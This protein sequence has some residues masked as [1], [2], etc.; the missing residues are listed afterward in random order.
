MTG[1]CIGLALDRAGSVVFSLLLVQ[2]IDA[3]TMGFRL[4]VVG[5]AH[6]HDR[7]VK[8]SKRVGVVVV[9]HVVKGGLYGFVPLRNALTSCVLKPT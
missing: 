6:H 9:T 2:P 7:Y 3:A 4:R 1:A 8:T 5:H